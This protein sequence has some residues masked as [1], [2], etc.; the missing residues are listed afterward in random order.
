MDMSTDLALPMLGMMVLTLLVW[1]F[2][3]IQRVGYA[4]SQKLDIEQFKTPA[5]VQVLVPA[6]ISGSSNN[7]RNLFELPVLFY[8]L[9]LYLMV[10]GQADSFYTNGPFWCCAAC[11]VLFTAA[12]TGWHTG[13]ASTFF[14]P[15][16]SGSWCSGR[17]WRRF[18]FLILSSW[19]ELVGFLLQCRQESGCVLAPWPRPSG[20]PSVGQE[21]D[22]AALSPST[23][24]ALAFYIPPEHTRTPASHRA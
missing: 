5:D 12:T 1:V 14:L 2:M 23:P 7:F 15:W 3:F 8:G 11:T 9:C 20:V 13:L 24:S 19:W 22:S 4:Q 18:E 17:S 16:C 6:E 10:S 21:P